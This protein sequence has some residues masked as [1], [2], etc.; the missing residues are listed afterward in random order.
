MGDQAHRHWRMNAQTVARADANKGRCAPKHSCTRQLLHLDS[1][2]G[3]GRLPVRRTRP[4]SAQTRIPER[5]RVEGRN[6]LNTRDHHHSVFA[7]AFLP[8]LLYVSRTA[9]TRANRQIE[10]RLCPD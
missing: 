3:K 8:P 1:P 7:T 2:M 10:E 5:L 4:S 9:P 6:H